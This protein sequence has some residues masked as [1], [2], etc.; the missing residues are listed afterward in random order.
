M[1]AGA[2]PDA[3]PPALV[4]GLGVTYQPIEG[5]AA[6]V[7][8]CRANVEAN[9]V[10][11]DNH[12]PGERGGRRSLKLPEK[13]P[14]ARSKSAQRMA[15]SF[16][17]RFNTNPHPSA[18]DAETRGGMRCTFS[19]ARTSRS[20]LSATQ[21]GVGD[22]RPSQL[23]CWRS[24]S[25]CCSSVSDGGI[26]AGGHEVSPCRSASLFVVVARSFC[27]SG[28]HH[29]SF[30][31][32]SCCPPV[33]P[34]LG[35]HDLRRTGL[36]VGASA[37]LFDRPVLERRRMGG[38]CTG[39]AAARSGLAPGPCRT[40]APQVVR[41]GRRG[42]ATSKCWRCFEAAGQAGQTCSA[43]RRGPADPRCLESQRNG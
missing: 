10:Y 8:R 34:Y 35:G 6:R 26:R 11:A 20:V 28:L 2:V 17:P 27:Y 1:K 5:A 12:L 23:Q 18:A 30:C 25:G 16:A 39:W 31:A 40:E 19:K 41:Q 32:P 13:A 9:F 22:V 38:T 15:A 29:A 33:A 3:A 24:S 42:A 7:V 43:D 21:L 36:R 14:V 37:H 4:E